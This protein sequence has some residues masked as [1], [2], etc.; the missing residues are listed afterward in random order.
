MPGPHV[1]PFL[2]AL[3]VPTQ[4]ETT[5][6]AAHDPTVYT[7]QRFAPAGGVHGAFT[8]H[9]WHTPAAHP[10]VVPSAQ[11]SPQV[12]Q[13]RRSFAV[14]LHVPLQLVVGAGHAQLPP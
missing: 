10:S 1:V 14:S 6:P 2:V 12:P 3:G 11:A 4:L 7:S 13:F 8:V 5:P 9:V